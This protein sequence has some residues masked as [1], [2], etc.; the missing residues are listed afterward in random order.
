MAKKSFLTASNVE[1]V[2]KLAKLTLSKAESSKLTSQLSDT[3]DYIE[4][5]NEIDTTKVEPTDNVTG[6]VNITRKDEIKDS[7]TQAEVLSS[8]KNVHN[9]FFKV[10]AVLNKDG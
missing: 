5:L 10:K 4:R 3:L 7:L 8:S 6:L 1:H 9:G 2:A